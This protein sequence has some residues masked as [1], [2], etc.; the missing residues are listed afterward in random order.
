MY[1]LQFEDDSPKFCNQLTDA[2]YSAAD[3]GLLTIIDITNNSRP[4][5]HDPYT[6]I[7][8]ELEAWD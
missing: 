1:I 3:D 7:W 2:E 4:L 8:E 6:G 5:I